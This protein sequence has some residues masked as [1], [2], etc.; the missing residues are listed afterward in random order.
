MDYV[1]WISGP[2]PVL[3]GQVSTAYK[4]PPIWHSQ[5]RGQGLNY[6]EDWTALSSP[7]II[8]PDQAWP[9]IGKREGAWSG[10]SQ[11]LIKYAAFFTYN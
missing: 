5:P 3:S 6:H 2:I 1:K 7:K 10:P 8:L 9:C 4:Q 11:S